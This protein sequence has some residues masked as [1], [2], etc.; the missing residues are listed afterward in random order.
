M[1]FFLNRSF[2]EWRG[3]M[4]RV[5]DVCIIRSKTLISQQLSPGILTHSRTLPDR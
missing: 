2:E 3:E 5:D 4:G 1:P